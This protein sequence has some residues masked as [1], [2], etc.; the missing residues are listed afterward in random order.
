MRELTMLLRSSRTGLVLMPD[1]N[2]NLSGLFGADFPR[3]KRGD[4][5]EGRGYL[6]RRGRKPDVV[7][8][9]YEV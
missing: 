7:Q 5:F 4:F 2:T 6:V 8:V 3:F 9:A 1:P